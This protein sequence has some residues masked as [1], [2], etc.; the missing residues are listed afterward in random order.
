MFGEISE[1]ARLTIAASTV[2]K[3]LIDIKFGIFGRGWINVRSVRQ[4]SD[5]V[6]LH[7]F[8]S[9]RS[10]VFLSTINRFL[11]LFFLCYSPWLL[12]YSLFFPSFFLL[13][14]VFFCAF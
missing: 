11:F 6:V 2:S 1:N 3:L 7:A 12:R 9:E 5:L 14:I 4:Q 13:L 8:Y 10:Y